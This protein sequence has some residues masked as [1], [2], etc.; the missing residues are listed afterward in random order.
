MDENEK[1]NYSCINSNI[2]LKILFFTKIWKLISEFLVAT[3]DKKKL[4]NKANLEKAFKI[5][6]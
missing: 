1:I 2:F 5:V 4:L 3:I 6:D